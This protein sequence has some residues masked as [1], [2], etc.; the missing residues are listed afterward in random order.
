MRSLNN[1]IKTE[2]LLFQERKHFF[3]NLI[4]QKDSCKRRL[5]WLDGWLKPFVEN[6]RNLANLEGKIENRVK[7]LLQ[8]GKDK[9][10]VKQLY[11][12]RVKAVIRFYEWERVYWKQVSE[13][14]DITL[15]QDIQEYKKDLGEKG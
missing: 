11:Q 15:V 6:E 12:D 14:M 3:D 10:Q 7:A 13:N 4:A 9:K 2:E 5:A 8:A 1:L